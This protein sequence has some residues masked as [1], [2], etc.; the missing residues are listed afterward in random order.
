MD[1]NC[2]FSQRHAGTPSLADFAA[3]TWTLTPRVRALTSALAT[4]MSLKVQV[5]IRMVPL[6]LRARPPGVLGPPQV[7][8]I[9]ASTRLRIAVRSA[10]DRLG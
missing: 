4:A 1:P 10:L 3:T 6:P 5:A 9:V 8:L 2:F 7:L